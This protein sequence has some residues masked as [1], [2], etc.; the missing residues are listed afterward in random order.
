MRRFI[1]AATPLL[2]LVTVLASA[3]GESS[4]TPTATPPPSRTPIT[5]GITLTDFLGR[6]VTVPRNPAKVVA[7][8]PTT[9]ELVY[10]VGGT[11]V[12]RASSANYPPEAQDV[13]DVGSSYQPSI[14]KI[15]AMQPDLVIADSQIQPELRDQA[16]TLGAPVIFAGA[17]V[18]ADVPRALRLVGLATGHDDEGEAAA[19]ALEEHLAELQAAIQ[20]THPNVLIINGTP[21]DF[22]AATSASYVGDLNQLLGGRNAAEGQP[23][24]GRFAGY[25]KLSTETILATDPDLILAISAVKEGDETISDRLK[26]DPAWSSLS[27]VE[28]G[29]VHEIDYRIFLIAPGPRAGEALDTLVRLLYPSATFPS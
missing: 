4:R 7:L 18:F 15:I 24:V 12:G 10:A 13:P 1:A 17:G 19:L 29:R 14:E 5:D 6:E 11:V 8:S 22:F 26:S 9:V 20:H 27:A 28:A 21:N 16:E 2:L 3:C 23:T 25:A